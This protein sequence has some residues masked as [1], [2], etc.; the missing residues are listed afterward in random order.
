MKLLIS[1]SA[2]PLSMA[3]P[4]MALL[5][6]RLYD[7]IFRK[8]GSGNKKWP[9][10]I[11][12]PVGS[13]PVKPVEPSPAVKEAV[14][15]R[16]YVVDNYLA[17]TAIQRDGK[18]TMRI[19]KLLSKDKDVLRAFE[20]D[21]KRKGHKVAQGELVV[22]ISRHPYDVIGM[23]F[24][25]GWTSSMNLKD[26]SNKKYLKEAVKAGVLVSYLVKATDA[27][28]NN[29]IARI[30]LVPYH[31]EAGGTILVPDGSHGDA[32][33]S[34]RKIVRT[35][36]QWANSGSPGGYYAAD[37]TVYSDDLDPTVFHGN[38]EHI[39]EALNQNA[40]EIRV[41]AIRSLN[42]TEANLNKALDDKDYTVRRVAAQNPSAYKAI[43]EKAL[44]DKD[45]TVRR[46]AAQ[47]PNATEA[48]LNKALDDKDYTVRRVAAQ[49]PNASKAILEKALSDTSYLV[50]AAAA[51][52]RNATEANLNKALDDE[53]EEARIEAARN[54]NA[55]EANLNK[56]LDDEAEEVRASAAENPSA[57]AANLNKALDDEAKEVRIEAAQ[58][59]NATRETLEKALGDKNKSV[60]FVAAKRLKG[61]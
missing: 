48:N 45:Y 13:K 19:G 29:P 28:I 31:R 21:P 47:N 2:V 11:Y 10:R 52:N 32:P 1:L 37:K 5:N 18:R 8:Y 60:K 6:R 22:V 26:G 14:E 27:N 35:F 9:A 41:R 20:S 46:V 49:N 54:R 53:A 59:P 30:L 61:D 55:T 44:S 40:V 3:K 36:C 42:A 16:G 12:I 58:N 15:S 38:S 17:G 51:R 43:L 56:A 24:D 50:R 25:R 33:A 4:Y 7:N 23:S 57:T 34:F 39:D